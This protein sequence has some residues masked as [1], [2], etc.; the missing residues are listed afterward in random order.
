MLL[1]VLAA[2]PAAAAMALGAARGLLGKVLRAAQAPQRLLAAGV[3][4]LLQLVPMVLLTV[5]VGLAEQ[6]LLQ[7]LQVLL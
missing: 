5:Q 6:R 3:E 7:Q 1:L 4:V 2:A